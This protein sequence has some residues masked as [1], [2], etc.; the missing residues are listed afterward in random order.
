MPGVA[1]KRG[2]I[3]SMV[4]AILCISA[5]IVAIATRPHTFASHREVV[6]AMIERHGYTM[7]AYSSSLKWPEGVNYY[8]YGSA[9]YPY[10]PTIQVRLADSREMEGMI[11]CRN[12]QYDCRLTLPELGIEREPMPDIQRKPQY[13]GPVWFRRL[14]QRIG[15]TL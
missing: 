4:S 11:E 5:M 1:L 6:A 14:L 10:S 7:V 15:V 12:D 3:A 9:V 8:A 13:K 2:A